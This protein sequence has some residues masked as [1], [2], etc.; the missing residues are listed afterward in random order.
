MVN[1][2]QSWSSPSKVGITEKISE[3]IHKEGPLKPRVEE[4]TRTLNQPI[5]KLD[6]ISKQLE[7]KDA[8]LFQRI[9]DAQQNHD[10]INAKGLATELGELRKHEKVIGNIRLSIERT[11]LRLSTVNELGDVMH[12]LG[13]AMSTMKAMGP[14]LTKFI[15]EADAEFSA[16]G[17]TLGGLFS[18]SFEGSFESSV[19][20]DEETELILQEASAVAEDQIGEKFPT[21]PTSLSSGIASTSE[22][23]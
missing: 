18:N 8:K 4:A 10:K 15:P 21:V 3:A 20:S 16:M 9:V 22:Q 13:P 6:S 1:F 17:D 5:S 7:Q 14:A 12:A 2:E 11:Q 23:N 19:G